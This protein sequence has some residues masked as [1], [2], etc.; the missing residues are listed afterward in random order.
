MRRIGDRVNVVFPSKTYSG[1][2]VD[3][4]GENYVV[5]VDDQGARACEGC[6][7]R[8]RVG[9]RLVCRPEMLRDG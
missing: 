3:M 4:S 1:T 8:M 5:E 6:A 2:V 7:D 9:Q